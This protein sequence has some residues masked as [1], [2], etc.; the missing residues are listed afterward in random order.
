MET[1]KEMETKEK[2]S[3]SS[4]GLLVYADIYPSHVTKKPD[5]SIFNSN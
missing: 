3:M 4:D 2:R 5:I 1:C